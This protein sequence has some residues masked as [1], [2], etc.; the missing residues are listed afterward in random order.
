MPRMSAA[1][2]AVLGSLGLIA[3]IAGVVA[4][5]HDMAVVGGA[6]LMIAILGRTIMQL[7]S[8]IA[9]I[10]DAPN[11]SSDNATRDATE[12]LLRGRRD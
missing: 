11:L 10:R 12:P 4:G 9:A 1:I 7:V 2:F 3:L 5:T 8:A 6:A